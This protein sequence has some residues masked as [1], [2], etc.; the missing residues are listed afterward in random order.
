MLPVD[1]CVP[2][3]TLALLV[4]TAGRDSICGEQG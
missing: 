4:S 1:M 2:S 3:H